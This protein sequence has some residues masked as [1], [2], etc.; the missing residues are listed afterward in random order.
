MKKVE[1]Y[2]KLRGG[3]YTPAPIADFIVRW[4]VRDSDDRVLEPSCGDG[5]FIRSIA[6]QYRRRKKRFPQMIGIELD[7]TEATKAEN[8]GAAIV[9]SD[10]FTYYE[11]SIYQKA[12][13]DV[14][15]GNPPFIR[16]QNFDEKY[17]KIAFSFMEKEGLHPG[18]LTNIWIPFL[19]LSS[20]ALSV[21]G[22]L[23]MVIPAE[24]MQVDY[25]AEV[26]DYLSKKFDRLTII[27]F[28]KLL[29]PNAQQEVVLLL[30]EKTSAQ[31]GIRTIE[32]NDAD[33]LKN[34][35]VNNIRYEIKDID[36]NT[37]KWTQYL[38][39]NSEI[40]LLRS[41]RS[42]V[43]LTQISEL[44]EVN[45]GVVSGENDFF[46]LND[47][48]RREYHLSERTEPIVGRADQLRG[49][50]FTEED[51]EKLT[52]AGKKIFLFTPQDEDYE[53]LS[54]CEKKYIDFGVLKKYHEGYKCKNRRHWYIVPRTWKADAFML[55]QVNKYPRI[56]FNDSDAQNTDTLHKVRFADGVDGRI[57]A[58]AFLNSFT[59][60]LCEIIGRSYGGGVLTFEPGEVRKI[61]IPMQNSERL[62]FVLI[63]RYV[64][65]GQIDALL[66]YTDRILLEQGLGLAYDEVLEVREIWHRLSNR[67]I[68]RKKEGA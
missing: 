6:S 64:R 11:K 1:G 44:L 62:D 3:Y 27:M 32:V 57:V 61:K 53:Q 10:F 56:V 19:V 2:D 36:H 16:S 35:N 22:R 28:K 7:Q 60:A 12:E 63:D 51:F 4:A 23:G 5:S 30:G 59:F 18:R 29:F 31:K 68:N 54:E 42:D 21:N 40:A 14:V 26:R 41:L 17:R 8:Q 52:R 20:C 46:L 25:A 65:N 37:E 50:D 13:F 45:V 38:L 43:R 47:Q 9:V 24:I 58:A 39:S 34:L 48:T 15:V 67:R 66:E 33:S 49:I 55:R